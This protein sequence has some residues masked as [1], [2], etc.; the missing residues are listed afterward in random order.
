M[1]LKYQQYIKEANVEA[2]LKC[3]ESIRPL[4]DAYSPADIAEAHYQIRKEL[5]IIVERAEKAK[6]IR[7]LIEEQEEDNTSVD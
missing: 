3:M 2:V 4:Y 5:D 7:K 6:R 1:T